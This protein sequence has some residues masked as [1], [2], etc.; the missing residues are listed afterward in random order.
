M[1]ITILAVIIGLITIGT[2]NNVIAFDVNHS[3]V[4]NGEIIYRDDFDTESDY[5]YY[6]H[7]YATYHSF[8]DGNVKLTVP[9]AN[10]KEFHVSEIWDNHTTPQYK[11][12]NMEIRLKVDKL[13]RGSKGW[14]F[15]NS[16]LNPSNCSL[17]WFIF[18]INNNIFYPMKGL[19][20]QVMDRNPFKMS[21]K[22]IRGVD[23]GKWHTYNINWT[24]SHVDFYVD[25]KLVAHV[26][27]DVPDVN[28]RTHIWND[29]AAW[30]FQP[31][32]Q[33]ILRPTSLIVDYLEI[34]E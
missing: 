14:G 21:I 24:E 12:N 25:E 7:T 18:Q 13:S 20:I 2:I 27:K 17:A 5:W 9:K 16:D 15:W 22:R 26:T 29:N 30:Y 28:C 19:W 34:T 11:Y 6:K 1:K 3:Q 31:I 33:R 8:E 32:F 4:T 10:R 23:I